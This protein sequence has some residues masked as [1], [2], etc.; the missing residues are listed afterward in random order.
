MRRRTPA[1]ALAPSFAAATVV[2]V[3][4]VL[5]ACGPRHLS[6]LG[7]HG[8]LCTERTACVD[9]TDCRITEAGY[10]CVGRDGRVPSSERESSSGFTPATEDD[11][12]SGEAPAPEGAEESPPGDR[13]GRRGRQ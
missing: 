12:E 11:E 7:N 8:D 4:L 9:G 6:A 10:R 3:V 2:V 5:N 13:G 1:R